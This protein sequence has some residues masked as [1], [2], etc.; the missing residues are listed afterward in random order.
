AAIT[1]VGLALAPRWTRDPVEG[2][3][4]QREEQAFVSHNDPGCEVAQGS[5]GGD[6]DHPI[7]SAGTT[8]LSDLVVQ[9]FEP[10]TVSGGNQSDE[11]VRADRAHAQWAF[12]QDG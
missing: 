5:L 11:R 10:L 3:R 4:C 7:G 6:R 2:R 1:V 9:G 8:L 12:R